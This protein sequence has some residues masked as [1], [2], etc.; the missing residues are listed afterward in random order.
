MSCNVVKKLNIMQYSFYSKKYI[1]QIQI[2][3]TINLIILKQLRHL[4]HSQYW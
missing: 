2:Y 1:K 3:N 4:F